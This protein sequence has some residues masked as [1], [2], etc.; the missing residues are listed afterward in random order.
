MIKSVGKI[1]FIC[2]ILL[3]ASCQN[4]RV[5]V[6]EYKIDFL[7]EYTDE[8]KLLLGEVIVVNK[9]RVSETFYGTNL[10]QNIVYDVWE[11]EYKNVNREINDTVFKN[12]YDFTSSLDDIIYDEMIEDVINELGLD[13]LVMI[14][15]EN[16]F[17]GY[18]KLED[19]DPRYY[20]VNLKLNDLPDELLI[21]I[22]PRED[23]VKEFNEALVDVIEEINRVQIKNVLLLYGDDA[24][25]MDHGKLVIDGVVVQEKISVE[26]SL[27]WIESNRVNPK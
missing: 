11:I 7:E 10:T 22:S 23:K 9:D 25:Q 8:I 24:Y 2:L 4:N 19:I 18:E 16:G 12:R 26:D 27:K 15:F 3:S 5:E 20:P 13:S 17:D 14:N 1:L 21:V 6:V